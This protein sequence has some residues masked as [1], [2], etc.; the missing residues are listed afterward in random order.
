MNRGTIS[1]L[2]AVLSIASSSFAQRG[3][4]P[5]TTA[6]SQ[7]TAK[8]LIVSGKVSWDAK[9]LLTDLDSEWRVENALVLKGYEGD[10]VR[11]RC[12]VDSDRNQ[13]H[14]LS[15]RK[16]TDETTYAPRYADSAFRR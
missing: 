10:L 14:I 12:L 5:A 2:V 3:K 7:A 8:T 1:V 4:G 11:V 6:H 13:I 9:T 15:L 16:E